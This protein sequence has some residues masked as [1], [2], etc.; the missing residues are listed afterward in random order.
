MKICDN[1]HPVIAYI[2]IECP[3]CDMIYRYGKLE[4]A[5]ALLIR[6]LEELKRKES[7]KALF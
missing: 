3:L 1:A 2:T 6:D 4:N 7:D 5:P